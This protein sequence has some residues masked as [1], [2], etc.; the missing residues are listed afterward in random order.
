MFKYT[1]Y[2]YFIITHFI[3]ITNHSNH[4]LTNWVILRKLFFNRL[5]NVYV[6]N[7]SVEEDTPMSAGVKTVWWWW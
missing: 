7:K 3:E 5:Y 6:D 1:V 4:S 2:I